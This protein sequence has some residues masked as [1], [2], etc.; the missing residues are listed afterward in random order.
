MAKFCTECGREIADGV[1][2]CTECG[3]KAPADAAPKTEPTVETTAVKVEAPPAAQPQY[4]PQQPQPQTYQQQQQ[5]YRPPAPQ[6]VAP[7]PV[8]S[9]APTNKVVGTG[10]FFGLMFLFA[11]P[12]VGL[13]ACI[14]MAFAPKNKN[15]KNY[16]RAMLIWTAIAL[17]ICGILI[18]LFSVLAGTVI[19]TINDSL[20]S[21]SDSSESVS[22]EGL[23]GLL[24][25][26][27]D[28]SKSFSDEGQDGQLDSS[29]SVSDEG[30]GG[31][32]GG[33]SDSSESSEEGLNEQLNEWSG[34]FEMF[35]NGNLGG[36]TQ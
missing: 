2:F 27:S 9:V 25:G 5:T 21:Y 33:W 35:G 18:A 15:I 23:G 31:L 1:A 13:I 16:A 4:P 19:N 6:P 12:I 24:G 17:V 26:W 30:L 3:T 10:T 28:S 29:E 36:L 34:I 8:S 11:L 32:L 7:Q 14:I 22:D 20:S